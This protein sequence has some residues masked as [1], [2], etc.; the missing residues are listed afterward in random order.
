MIKQAFGSL[1]RG[2]LALIAASKERRAI[3]ELRSFDR[4]TL[5]DIGIKRGE[6]EFAVRHGR[7]SQAKV[8]PFSPPTKRRNTDP[9]RSRER[10]PPLHV[11]LL[12]VSIVPLGR[13]CRGETSHLK[14]VCHPPKERCE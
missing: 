1:L 6:I 3:R 4:R 13:C 5:A 7:P 2:T 12:I 10:T 9:S 14:P 11:I 8:V